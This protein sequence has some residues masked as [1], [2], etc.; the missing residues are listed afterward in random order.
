MKT[1]TLAGI[2]LL[3]VGCAAQNSTDVDWRHTEVNGKVGSVP[4]EFEL[5]D[6]EITFDLYQHNTRRLNGN[7]RVKVEHNEVEY[8]LRYVF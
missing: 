4:Y 2:L 6:L 3:C 8:E 7:H 5:D 1:I